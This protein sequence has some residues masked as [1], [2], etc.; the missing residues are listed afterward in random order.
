MNG[1]QKNN[2]FAT[3]YLASYGKNC[4]FDYDTEIYIYIIIGKAGRKS[5]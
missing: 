1:K 3:P 5:N 4:I 2:R